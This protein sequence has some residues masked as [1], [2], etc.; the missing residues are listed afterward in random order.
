MIFP[1]ERNLYEFSKALS[2]L[3][4]NYVE[5]IPKTAFED[6]FFDRGRKISSLDNEII[7]LAKEERKETQ[8][9]DKSKM[10]SWVRSKRR[11]YFR[12]KFG[13]KLSL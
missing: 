13:I 1:G 8:V 7:K 10:P 6:Y 3:K 12:S 9:K 2:Y 11:K 5:G 4:F